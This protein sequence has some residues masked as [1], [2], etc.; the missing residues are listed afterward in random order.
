MQGAALVSSGGQ[1]EDGRNRVVE[2]WWDIVASLLSLVC[3]ALVWSI[4]PSSHPAFCFSWGTRVGG[5]E[6]EE[7]HPSQPPPVRPQE[8]GLLRG[9]CWGGIHGSLSFRAVVLLSLSAL[10]C[11]PA[12]SPHPLP[13][14]RLWG[15]S[16]FVLGSYI[17]CPHP[18]ASICPGCNLIRCFECQVGGE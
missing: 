5:E 1:S 11:R 9:A 18:T 8:A 4:L 10:L 6:V 16:S 15:C 3:C 7:G 2:P 17:G 13:S 12:S 14:K